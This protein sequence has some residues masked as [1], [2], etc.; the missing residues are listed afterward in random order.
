MRSRIPWQDAAVER[1]ARPSDALHV[2]HVG[3]VIQ[4][5]VMVL[6]FLDDA[7][8]PG[9]RLASLRAARNRR[10][11]DP[12]LGFVYFNPLVAE[13]N[14]GHEGITGTTRLNSPDRTFAASVV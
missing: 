11:Q 12:P 6:Y 14:D 7:E 1:D 10:P 4:V 3:I 9:G 2:R 13:R 5:R 8:D